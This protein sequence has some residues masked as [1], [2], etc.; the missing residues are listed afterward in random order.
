[1][2][3]RQHSRFMKIAQRKGYLSME[4]DNKQA[5]RIQKQEK[6]LIVVSLAVGIIMLLSF[7][8]RFF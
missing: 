5:N 2:D 1:M 6:W 7:I 4:S 8:R 3:H